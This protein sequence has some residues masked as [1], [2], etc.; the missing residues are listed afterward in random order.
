MKGDPS[1]LQ[2]VGL[3][4]AAGELTPGVEVDPDE[5]ALQQDQEQSEDGDTKQKF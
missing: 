1:L 5:L 2:E 3:D 4:V